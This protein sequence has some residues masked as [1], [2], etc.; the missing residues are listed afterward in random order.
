MDGEH[1]QLQTPSGSARAYAAGRP[2]APLVVLLMD[3]FGFRAA[4]WS[5]ADRF[6]AD[7]FRVVVPD[8]FHRLGEVLF[9]PA[10]VART[11]DGFAPVRALLGRLSVADVAEDVDAVLAREGRTEASIV[12]Y[13]MGGRFGYLVATER[14]AITAV[15]AIHTGNLVTAAP[16]SP[17]RRAAGLRAALYLAIAA[18]DAGFTAAHEEELSAAFAA[19]GVTA[20]FE[21]YAG[22]HGFAVPDTPVFEPAS[23]DRHHTA[24]TAFLSPR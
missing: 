11:P 9:D 22:R 7:G 23:A 15:A 19:A 18:D 12:G 2:G 1:F 8:V 5:L 10:E 21:R 17:H 16:D 4:I 24:V 20:T 6:A 3:A 14:P 13:C